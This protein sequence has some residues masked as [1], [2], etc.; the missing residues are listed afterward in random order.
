MVV[1]VVN[2][3]KERYDVYI[4]RGTQAGNPFIVGP[5]GDNEECVRKY[6][7]YFY[8]RLEWDEDFK[9]YIMSLKGIMGC[10]CKPLPC[11]GDVIAEYR[12]KEDT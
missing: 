5:D 11:H 12:N 6:R 4:G 9:K 8:W 3:K 10:W 7:K 1:K 2:R